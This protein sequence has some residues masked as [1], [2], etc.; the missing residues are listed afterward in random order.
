MGRS[1]VAWCGSH[2]DET[3]EWIMIQLEYGAPTDKDAVTVR[4]GIEKGFFRRAGIDLRMRV[5]FGGPPLAA[6]YDAG[7]VQM[8]EIG[9]PPAIAALGQGARFVIVGSGIWRKAHMYFGARPGIA[10]W[11][12]MRGRRLGLLTRGSCPEWFIRGMLV[13]HG[14]DPEDHLIYVP[15]HEEY[16]RIANVIAEGRIDAG[17]MVEP[18]MSLAEYNGSICCWGAVYEQPY[19]P[20]FQ[21]VVQVARP[22]FIAHEPELLR[23]VLAVTREAARYA[24]ANPDEFAEFSSRLFGI[25]L[26]VA[27][28]AV[29]RQSGHLHLDGEVDMAGLD[30]M[31]VLQRRLG[32]LQRPMRAGDI[33]DLRFSESSSLNGA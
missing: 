2:D 24:A 18:N 23:A 30:E 3:W 25:P 17:I 15:L 6:A 10:S 27:R 20:N 29:A 14:F 1:Y 31:I 4:F 33:T 9:S 16:A 19:F 13:Q 26:P 7:V 28:T 12:E 32:A 5:I 8:G 22:D 11:E 21:W